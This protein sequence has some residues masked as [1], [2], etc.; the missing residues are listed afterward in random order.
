M[1]GLTNLEI[2]LILVIG[3]LAFYLYFGGPYTCSTEQPPILCIDCVQGYIGGGCTYTDEYGNLV[4]PDCIPYDMSKEKHNCQP[5]S[6]DVDVCIEIYQPVCGNDAETYS[7]SCFACMN[8]RVAFYFDGECSEVL[9]NKEV[10]CRMDEDCACGVNNET[11]NCF[12]GNKN[13]VDTS[14]QCPDFCTGIGGNLVID[15]IN[16]RCTQIS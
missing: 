12:Y 14:Q 6:R 5:E 1:K 7:N 10:Y 13:Y 3:V 15:C 8:E 2:F 4:Q 9:I 11:G 16:N